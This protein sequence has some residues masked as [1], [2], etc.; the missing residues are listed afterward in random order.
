MPPFRPMTSHSS[1]MLRWLR[2]AGLTKAGAIVCRCTGSRPPLPS[3][4]HVLASLRRRL[5][6]VYRR[7][8]CHT[9]SANMIRRVTYLDITYQCGGFYTVDM[10]RPAVSGRSGPCGPCSPE[11]GPTLHSDFMHF[12]VAALEPSDDVFSCER[13][14]EG[15][16]VRQ[17]KG[18]IGGL[19]YLRHPLSRR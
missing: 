15:G 10:S 9:K 1:A 13:V 12:A 11:A 8:S 3:R 17:S 14:G 6:F 19:R 2:Y 4:P 5:P 16:Q 18:Q 7:P